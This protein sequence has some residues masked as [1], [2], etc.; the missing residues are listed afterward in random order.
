MM[1]DTV[2][3]SH[4]GSS[5]EARRLITISIPVYDEAD[6]IAPL[7]KRVR[8]V[9]HGIA[10]YDFE[11]LFTDNA[12]GDATFERLTE[13]AHRDPRV[14]VLR[15]S[16]NFGFQLSILTNY[17]NARGVAAIQIDADLEDPPE[18]IP[19]MIALWEK[20]YKVVYG[21]RRKRSELWVKTLMRRLFYRLVS[22]LSDVDVPNDAGDFRLVD[23][24]IIERLRETKDNNPYLRGTIA[25]FGYPQ[26]GILYD[27]SARTAGRSKFSIPKLIRFG[28][29]GICSQS[30]KPL[31]LITFFGLALSILSLLG[32]LG[33]MAWYL[34]DRSAKPQ[35]FTTIVLL[36][37]VTTG[38]NTAFLGLL[39]E[40]VGRIFRNTRMVPA[41][42]I[43]SRI[44]H[45]A[46]LQSSQEK[47]TA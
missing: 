35:G 36:M 37:L 43:E 5:A 10:G 45:P 7:L 16:R 19:E 2:S 4:D 18:L 26:T 24:E 28:M 40:Y 32:A 31:E 42:I 1:A 41:P 8:A 20:G 22:R 47:A 46:A 33:Y 25:A 6:N 9:T 15:F 11:F 3:S 30:T 38:I 44:E 12:S 14:R 17:L 21:I 27:R 29:D 39:G 34:L 13:E 23:R